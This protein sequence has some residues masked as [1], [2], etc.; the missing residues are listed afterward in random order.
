MGA[1]RDYD[2]QDVDFSDLSD[3]NQSA[4]DKARQSWGSAEAIR[5]DDGYNPSSLS[6]A[7]NSS[8]SPELDSNEENTLSKEDSPWSNNVKGGGTHKS[9]NSAQQGRFSKI[10]SIF[11]KRGAV[12]A[13]GGVAA[14]GG[15]LAFMFSMSL[16][17]LA[18][19]HITQ[20]I[21]EKLNFAATS[22]DGGSE[23]INVARTKGVSCKTALYCRFSTVSDKQLKKMQDAGFTINDGLEVEKTAFG[24]TKIQKL[25]YTNAAGKKI[26]I[27]N[28]T[29]SI[30]KAFRTNA[31]FR[32]A[33]KKAYSGKF[34]SFLDT[35]W[36]KIRGVFGWSKYPKTDEGKSPDKIAEDI[37]DDANKVG[38]EGELKTGDKKVDG[39]VEGGAEFNEN[40]DKTNSFFDKV[41]SAGSDFKTK[42]NAKIDDIKAKAD[43]ASAA[44][45]PCA[46]YQVGNAL[47]TGVKGIK[48]VKLAAFGLKFISLS[49]KIMA[50]DATTEEVTYLGDSIA[51]VLRQQEKEEDSTSSDSDTAEKTPSEKITAAFS[52]F[53]D[54]AKTPEKIEGFTDSQGWKAIAYGDTINKKDDYTEKFSTGLSG[55]I[56]DTFYGVRGAL[57]NGVNLLGGKKKNV[58]DLCDTIN[59]VVGDVVEAILT[60]GTLG[61]GG[62]VKAAVDYLAGE[63]MGLVIGKMIENLIPILAGKVISS[64]MTGKEY[65][66]AVMSGASALMGQNS[67]GGGGSLL[68]KTEAV[69]LYQENERRIA[70]YGE[71]VR[72]SM[73][74]FDP[75]NRHTFLGSIVS[76]IVPYQTQLATVS[77]FI[78][79][80][81]SI[82]KNSFASI[83]PGASAA[84]TAG[85]KANMEACDDVSIKDLN[86]A[87][88]IYCNPYSGTPVNTL[89]AD[90][91]TI[92]DT[93]VGSGDLN[94]DEDDPK[95]AIIS[96]SK[97]S[98]YVKEC[99]ERGD[100][101][102]GE[103]DN[104]K[105]C[106]SNE[107]SMVQYYAAYLNLVR[108]DAGMEEDFKPDSGSSSSSGSSLKGNS[109]INDRAIEIARP[110]GSSQTIET[111]DIM[112]QALKESG[113]DTYGEQYV[114]QGASCDAYVTMV[115]R[116]TVDKDFACCGVIYNQVPYLE[117]S[118]KYE[119]LKST[120][121]A[122]LKPGDILTTDGGGG[123]IMMYVEKDGVGKMAM[124]S[125]GQFTGMLFN[126]A[127]ATDA[128]EIDSLGRTF[129]AWR[130]KG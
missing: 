82:V 89:N 96:G 73:S 91:E 71:E 117:N 124:A 105:G 101:P 21:T 54:T 79:S 15:G 68:T 8:V 114:I 29:A 36:N 45:L 130:Y 100:K 106:S 7:E 24:R 110:E 76:S 4:V 9:R 46:V 44:Q 123:H 126:A 70:E 27:N 84:D 108:V 16:S 107:N 20:I 128:S 85:F 30:K 95:K 83:L 52:Y 59:G 31:E 38:G 53:A 12:I 69:A 1:M 93:L 41:K 121:I 97:L 55:A 109:T 116:T 112:K 39:E 6:D 103:G 28:D 81:F 2:D 118:G 66:A 34:A 86:I 63:A 25:E 104:D 11:K 98:K 72:L 26:T 122:D 22:L 57:L 120:K 125:Y 18:P 35:S 61:V 14:G 75:T 87:T 58:D 48:M 13:A 3:S 74:P 43:G 102:V 113:L 49:Q 50:G 94:P 42:A 111:T 51:G 10:K 92:V 90:M 78:P 47:S 80:A 65:G 119:E 67:I 62:V 115:M 23:T 60:V 40:L 99:Q 5:G 129:R 64:L 32:S 127:G 17:A 33:Y 77:G 19:I 37:V 88:D 56:A